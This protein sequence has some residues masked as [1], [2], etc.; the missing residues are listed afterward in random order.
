MTSG[1]REVVREQQGGTEHTM[2]AHEDDV[3]LTIDGRTVKLT[4]PDKVLFPTDE[5]TKADLVD[6]YGRV[7]EA[8]VPH[9]RGRPLMLQRFPDGID[10]DA[11]VQ[12]AA[13]DYFPDW[14]RRAEMAKRGGTV[15]H[16]VCEDTATLAYLAGQAC[17]TPHRWLS[18]IDHPDHPDLVVF[19]LDPSGS[20]PEESFST[21][22]AAAR[23]IGAVLESSGL[24]PF[25]QTTG[26]RGLHVVA[27]LDRGADFDAVRAFSRAVADVVAADDPQH[28]TT[29]QRKQKRHGRVY[30]DTMRNAYAQ[31]AVAPYAARAR[32][33]APVATPIDWREL[34]GKEMGPQR[35]TIR[36]VIRRL[37]QRNDPWTDLDGHA[38]S[39]DAARHRFKSHHGQATRAGQS[40][41]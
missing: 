25:V 21:V 33:G 20:D 22:R 10:E 29:E 3:S 30:I 19:D 23:S 28:L 39:L 41:V 9:L 8:M 35:F 17:I 2:P 37:A 16:V 24:V 40:I 15:R 18:R 36:S 14:V 4:R 31:T 32:P 27:P 12:Q 5:I 11:I 34:S 1:P 6:Y 13:P 26:S 7:A 38:A